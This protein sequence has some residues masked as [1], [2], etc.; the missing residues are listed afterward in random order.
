MVSQEALASD[1]VLI[2]SD[3]RS[4]CEDD[5]VI[6]SSRGLSTLEVRTISGAAALLETLG[7]LAPR[8]VLVDF[9]VSFQRGLDL[10]RSLKRASPES[11]LIA[12][13]RSTPRLRSLRAEPLYFAIEV[14][15]SKVSLRRLGP[16][17]V[18][19]TWTNFPT[20]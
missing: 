11:K 4:G 12:R 16:E 7:R 8:R 15:T 20:L 18:D 19:V 5:F 9:H 3:D 17:G 1:C 2:E 13:V 6:L 14:N 10:I